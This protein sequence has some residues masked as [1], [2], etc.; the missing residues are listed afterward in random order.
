MPKLTRKMPSFEGVAAGQTATLRLPIGFSYH[1]ALIAYSG[2]TLAQME[3]IRVVANGKTIQRHLTGAVLDAMNQFDGM[4][5]ASGVLTIDFERF[6]L[7]TRAGSELT[8]IGTGVKDDPMP[9]STLSIEI[10]IAAAAAAPVLSC[11]AI[12]SGPKPSG[13]IKQVRV[14]GHDPSAIGEYEIADL[15]RLGLINRV[16][17]KSASTI[18][19]LKLERDGHVV[20]ERDKA[21]N[22]VVQADGV[23]VVQAGYYAIDFSEEGNG[24]D[25]LDVSNVHDLRFTLDMAAAGHVDAIVE[26]LAPLH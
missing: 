9:I 2:V 14:F 23:R 24:Q 12:Q 18:N 8:V 16:I 10:D 22:E 13:V 25:A 26:Y 20:F 15:P 6:G 3:E 5:A 11:K 1:K 19:S 17:F 7:R 4:A 21:E